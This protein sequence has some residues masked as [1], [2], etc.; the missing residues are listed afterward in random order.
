MTRPEAPGPL[1]RRGPRPLLLHLSLA[2]ARS[3]SLT[4][5]SLNWS[6]V[7]P[8]LW[9]ANQIPDPARLQ[10]TFEETLKADRA[11]IAGIAAYRAAPYTRQMPDPPTRWEE[12]ESR[13]LDYGGDGPAVL[14]VPSLINRAY[15]LDLMEGGSML[16]WL[17]ANGAHPYLLDWG[18]PSAAERSFTLTDYIAGRLERALAAIPGP[19]VLAGYCMGGLLALAAALRAPDKV[20]ALALL[21]TPWDFH[22]ADA[23]IGPRITEMLPAMESMMGFSGTLPIDALNTLFAMID[24]YGVGEK[25]RDFATQDLT[26]ARAR[27]FV[28]MEDWLADGV[29]LASPV[30]REALG[31][32]Y[33][34]NT[35]ARGAWHVA[36]LAVDPARLRVPVFCAIPGRDRLVPAASALPLAASFPKATIIEP[37]AGHI[38]MVAGTRA[39][40]ALWQPFA[41]WLRSL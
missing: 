23:A 21:A 12:G 41:D 31:G 27:R 17:S 35:P 30:A 39:Q 18:W 38:G 36:G 22:A 15:I 9:Q 28:A 8:N 16:R 19:V 6:T 11:L 4:A 1:S 20:S 40:A 14:F 7:W 34:A 13:L 32:W 37:A 26:S 5:A 33:G 24:P 2:W 10:E 3:R 25:Y 29:P